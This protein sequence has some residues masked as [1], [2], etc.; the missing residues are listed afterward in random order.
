M[1]CGAK[2]GASGGLEFE[3]GAVGDDLFGTQVTQTSAGSGSMQEVEWKV[4]N[5][6][7]MVI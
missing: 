6:C 2:G 4:R 7:R 3:G 5:Y 1:H